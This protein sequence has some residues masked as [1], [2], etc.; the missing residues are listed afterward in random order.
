[1]APISE[2]GTFRD[3]FG[4]GEKGG[5]FVMSRK[6][7]Y[8]VIVIA[9]VLMFMVSAVGFARSVDEPT[10]VVPDLLFGKPIGFVGLVLGTA[11]YVVTLPVTVPFG[12]QKTA[13]EPLVKK[14]YRWTFQRGLGEDLDTY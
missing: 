2:D 7:L 8:R 1:M 12:W 11:T 13:Y 6:G 10:C 9:C 4:R 14:P 3:V 5:Y